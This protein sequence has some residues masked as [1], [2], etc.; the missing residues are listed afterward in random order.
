VST[1]RV[2]NELAACSL[3]LRSMAVCLGAS[4]TKSPTMSPTKSP[5]KP[6]T[7]HPT[8]ACTGTSFWIYNPTTNQPIR[9]IANNTATCLAHPYNVEIR[10]CSVAAILSRPVRIRL[11][12]ATSGRVV[13]KSKLQRRTPLF[14]FGPAA[15]AGDVLPS[16]G[17]LPH[18]AYQISATGEAGWGR[19]LFRQSCP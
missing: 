5:T 13:H 14:L 1:P 18:G 8:I 2:L 7:K 4:P 17:S 10:P 9:K 15:T 11:V 16:P 19:L 3:T 6:P 12:N